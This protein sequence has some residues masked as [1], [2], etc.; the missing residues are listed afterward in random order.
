MDIK[1]RREFIRQR[2][3]EGVPLRKIAEE[4]GTTYGAIHQADRRMRMAAVRTEYVDCEPG[5][6]CAPETPTH[7]LEAIDL[8]CDRLL[9]GK[10]YALG[11]QDLRNLENTL[12]KYL[13]ITHVKMG[14]LN[15]SRY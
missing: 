2:R 7:N 11:L 8:S 5:L 13:R 10:L 15:G 6:A 9:S 14:E 1:G 3:E 4:L 12:Q